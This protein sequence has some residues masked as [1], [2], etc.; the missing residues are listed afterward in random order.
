MERNPRGP[1]GR[2]H[3]TYTYDVTSDN[4][5]PL[6][7]VGF[8]LTIEQSTLQR[9]FGRFRGTVTDARTEVEQG[10]GTLRGRVRGSAILFVKRMPI[11]FVRSD[12]RTMLL[13]ERVAELGYPG[14]PNPKGMPVRYT[15]RFEDPDRASGVWIV[16]ARH[17]RVARGVWV[18]TAKTT[19]TW[20]MLR[21]AAIAQ[22]GTP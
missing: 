14:L 9:F 21:S 1:C 4:P 11:A 10:T 7:S 3:G 8:E 15:G 19:G 2:W 17:V 5:G 18:R 20:T 22:S 16:P 6:R 12:G 13:S